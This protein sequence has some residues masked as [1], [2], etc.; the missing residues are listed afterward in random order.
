VSISLAEPDDEWKKTAAGYPANWS[1][2]AN[3]DADMA[4]DLRF[5]TPDFYVLDKRHNIRFKHLS[6]DQILDV[7]RQLKKR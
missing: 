3:P 2:G 4:V 7:T 5:G 1:I 6:V